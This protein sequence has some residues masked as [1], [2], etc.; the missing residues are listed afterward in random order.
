M[1]KKRGGGG[2]KGAKGNVTGEGAAKGKEEDEEEDDGAYRCGNCDAP[3]A[4]SKCKGGG[5]VYYCSRECQTVRA[6]E[7]EGR[8]QGEGTATARVTPCA[9]VNAPW[10]WEN[11]PIVGQIRGLWVFWRYKK[12]F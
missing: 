10:I 3:D 6:H 8:L 12:V 2:K 1:A 4:K 7:V 11:G 5:V 9:R